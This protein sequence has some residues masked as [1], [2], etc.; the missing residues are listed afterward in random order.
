[1][2][3]AAY[4]CGDGTLNK[5]LKK[6]ETNSYWD[7]R[8][9]LPKQ[10]QEF[11]PKFIAIAYLMNY[12]YLHDIETNTLTDDYKFTAT[13]QVKDKIDLDKLSKDFD[14]DKELLRRLNPSFTK[15]FIP[16]SKDKEYR[17]TLPEQK[18][19]EFANEY[20]LLEDIISY[21]PQ[22]IARNK[23]AIA[24]A[25]TNNLIKERN[26]NSAPLS[27]LPLNPINAE[28]NMAAL[29]IEE[30]ANTIKV[31][32]LKKGQSLRD[33][34]REYNQELATLIQ[35]NDFNENKLPRVG[36]QIKVK[37]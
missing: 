3:L 13:L 25:E 27:Q 11:I 37:I 20:N 15:G 2:V 1:L 7:V 23:A 10:T 18:M 9:H 33:I 4:N 26:I 8:K 36:D 34:A 31:V 14:I 12:Y 32:K 35:N 28:I 19:Y 24:L 16:A 17:L 5:A 22:V 6:S 30:K 21:S 29:R